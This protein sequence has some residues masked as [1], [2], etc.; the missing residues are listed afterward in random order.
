MPQIFGRLSWVFDQDYAMA[1]RSLL[2]S[3]CL[4]NHHIPVLPQPSY[5]P[6][7]AP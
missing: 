2:V 4:S 7:L 3:N 5:S 1:H 6:D